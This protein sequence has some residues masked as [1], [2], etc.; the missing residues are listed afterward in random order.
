MYT[1]NL[2]KILVEVEFL[3]KF[4]VSLNYNRVMGLGHPFPDDV[5]EGAIGE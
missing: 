1:S 4:L 5:N 2:E 3:E